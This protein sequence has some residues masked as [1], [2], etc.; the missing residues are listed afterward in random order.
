MQTVSY[1]KNV[2]VDWACVREPDTKFKPNWRVDL[3]LEEAQ[4]KAIF[5][6][7]KPSLKA[8]VSDRKDNAKNAQERELLEAMLADDKALARAIFT[9]TEAGNYRLRAKR[10]ASPGSIPPAVVD[11][12]KQPLNEKMIIAKGDEVNL[13]VIPSAWIMAGKTCGI[14]LQLQ[15]VQLV[16]KAARTVSHKPIGALT[17][18]AAP[19]QGGTNLG[20]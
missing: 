12:N 19:A 15:G 20:F 5:E 17:W 16:K 18:D 13:A 2:I 9:K 7:L 6:Q 10:D 1:I 8:V 4:A 3:Q 11:G 14:S